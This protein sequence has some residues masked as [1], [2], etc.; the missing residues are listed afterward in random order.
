MTLQQAYNAM[1]AYFSLPGATLAWD[2]ERGSCKYRTSDG[3]ACAIGCL[4]P[5]ALYDPEFD[6]TG[7]EQ[8]SDGE[9]I[10]FIGGALDYEILTHHANGNGTLAD[11][12][13]I[14]TER[15]HEDRLYEFLRKAQRAH[16]SAAV[17]DKAV[18]SVGTP[19]TQFITW[20]DALAEEYGLEVPTR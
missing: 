8:D 17:P 9:W 12:F 6:H 3:R 2:A 16:D 15:L 7:E 13:G 10:E 5:P 14:D 18:L 19:A 4:I 11:F 20:L 1:R